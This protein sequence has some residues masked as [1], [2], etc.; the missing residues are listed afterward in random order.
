MLSTDNVDAVMNDEPALSGASWFFTANGM[1]ESA[2]LPSLPKTLQASV[3]TVVVTAKGETFT[4][5]TAG[6]YDTESQASGQL[7]RI[8]NGSIHQFQRPAH[9]SHRHRP[10][11]RRI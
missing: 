2:T 1:A 11:R 3:G 5:T 6:M 7:D 10:A 8:V 9:F 4:T